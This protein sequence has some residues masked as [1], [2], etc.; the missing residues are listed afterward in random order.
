MHLASQPSP[1]D[2]SSDT[3]SAL[4]PL[5]RHLAP[6]STGWDGSSCSSGSGFFSSTTIGVDAR[7]TGVIVRWTEP[8]TSVAPSKEVGA[9]S[10]ALLAAEVLTGTG[11]AIFSLE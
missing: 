11:L 10:V 6:G 9:A 7:G 5:R 4:H 8:Y 3:Y 2:I 1:R